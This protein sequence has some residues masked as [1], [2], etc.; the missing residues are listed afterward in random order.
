MKAQFGS[1]AAAVEDQYL[2]TVPVPVHHMESFYNSAAE[3]DRN[4]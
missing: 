4:C 2:P 1:T 3:P